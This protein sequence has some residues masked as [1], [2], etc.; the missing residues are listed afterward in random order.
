MTTELFTEDLISSRTMNDLLFGTTMGDEI[1]LFGKEKQGQTFNNPKIIGGTIVRPRIIGGE[2]ENMTFK[3]A[4]S[5]A[6]IEIFPDTDPT[7]GMVIYDDAN[8]EVFKVLIAG[9]D[10]GDV[11]LGDPSTYYAK[12]DKSVGTLNVVGPVITNIQSGSE[13]AIQGW[14]HDMSF[15]ATDHNTVAWGSGTIT[16][17]DGTT[18][19]INAGNTGAMSA[20]TYIYLDI[21]TSTTVLQ[22]TTTAAT[23]VG[24]GKILIATAQNVASGKKA[25]FQVFG[26]KALGGIGKLITADEIAANTITASEIAANTITANEM[27]VGSLSAISADLGTITA[28]NITLDSSGYIR[29][30]QTD[31]NTGAGF[32]LGYSGAAYKFSIG[33]PTGHHLTWDGS[34]LEAEVR[35]RMVAGDI[36]LQSADTFREESGSSYVKHKSIKVTKGGTYRIKFDLAHQTGLYTSY[37]RIYRNGVAVGTE[38]TTTETDWQT[39]SEDISGWAPG[40]EIQLYMKSEDQDAYCRNFRVYVDSYDGSSVEY[41]A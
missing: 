8:S 40:D 37:G 35:S 24:T 36:L 11:I 23:A 3:S 21:G 10:V 26:G 32:F 6:R 17:L 33:D 16:L 12:W 27:N 20:I 13:I 28:G 18:Y 34:V 25:L 2:A 19:S 31:Y 29:G 7:I 41:D 1:G 30:G 22:T 9:T 14:Q 39:Y 15:S 38:R 5:G 4:Q